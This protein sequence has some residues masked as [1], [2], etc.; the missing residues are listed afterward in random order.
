MVLAVLYFSSDTM[1]IELSPP[2]RVDEEEEEEC[3]EVPSDPQEHARERANARR[4]ATALIKE[5]ESFRASRSQDIDDLAWILKKASDLSNKLMRIMNQSDGSDPSSGHLEG[6]QEMIFKGNRLLDRLERANVHAPTPTELIRESQPSSSTGLP[7]L[8]LPK[9]GGD[10]VEWRPFIAQFDAAVQSTSI[11]VVQ[12]LIY[13]FSCLY[14][15]AK[16]AVLSL[17]LTSA[18]YE[19]AREILKKRF[20]N[21]ANLISLYAHELVTLPPVPDHDVQ[22]FRKFLDK[23]TSAHRELKSLLAEVQ[24]TSVTNDHLLGPLVCSKL[25][26]SLQIVWS[27]SCSSPCERFNLDR[28]IGFAEQEL[29]ALKSLPE[30]R[31]HSVGRNN[32]RKPSAA[33]V[34]ADTT[35]DASLC[36]I[37]QGE[38]VLS[39]C[40]E[41]TQ[42]SPEQRGEEVKKL[43]R[44]FNCLGSHYRD[45]CPSPKSCTVCN[46]RHHSMLHLREPVKVNA[47]VTQ[48][49]S[50]R[51]LLQTAMV[52][53]GTIGLKARVLL[54]SG[55]ERSYVSETFSNKIP[56]I[57]RSCKQLHRYETFGGFV[58]EQSVP[59]VS[60]ALRSCHSSKETT[61]QLL[62]LPKLCSPVRAISSSLIKRLDLKECLADVPDVDSPVDI[63]LGADSLPQVLKTTSPPKLQSGLLLVD[64]IFG[65]VISGPVADSSS[66]SLV[67]VSKVLR[68][69]EEKI[70]DLWDLEVFGVPDSPSGDPDA[71]DPKPELLND[72]YYVSLP[73]MSEDRPKLTFSQ[74]KKWLPRVSHGSEK[75]DQLCKVF[76]EYHALGILE[77]SASPSGNFLPYHVVQSAQKTRVVYNASAKPWHGSSL[78]D[79]LWSGPNLL[80]DL[81]N[82]LIRF[83]SHKFCV[84]ADIEKAFLMVG[85]R[86]EDRDMLKVL[87]HTREGAVQISR[88]ARVPF[89]LNCGPYLLLVALGQHFEAIKDLGG[90]ADH[91]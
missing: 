10:P 66:S 27:R 4:A 39:R 25:P 67:T 65:F 2:R 84:I 30:S 22:E 28:V 20:G 36:P 83:R 31:S 76:E 42:L 38:H 15:E 43:R 6:I 13:L 64:T 11:P 61:V 81:V 12:K 78:N 91:W 80:A 63:L 32:Q 45:A 37:C 55:A 62:V 77:S 68:T 19:V 14:G 18:N 40:K 46:R 75:H 26:P 90:I 59:V 9:F 44:C 82:I 89:G 33:L 85:V 79:L 35:K 51:T 69:C 1:T 88:F 5:F 86:H 17:P 60:L 34:T 29:A 7:R 54:D 16:S 52:R 74:A 48:A 58:H 71:V 53:V 24:D 87:W 70:P 21:P 8:E 57:R 3:P 56:G 23:F 41:F 50:Q 73:W 47:S 72:R 49:R